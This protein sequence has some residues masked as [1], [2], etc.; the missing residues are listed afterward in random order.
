[1]YNS[2]SLNFVCIATETNGGQGIPFS[3]IT[4]LV[5]GTL[6]DPFDDKSVFRWVSTY[7]GQY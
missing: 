6:Y 3:G 7:T 2:Y 1:V 4:N 5:V